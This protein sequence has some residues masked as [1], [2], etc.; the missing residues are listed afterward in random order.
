MKQN[1]RDEAEAVIQETQKLRE[2]IAELEDA[3]RTAETELETLML[4]LPNVPHESVPIGTSPEDNVIQFTWGTIPTFDFEPR[5]HWEL[6]DL[7]SLVDFERGAKVTGAGFPF[8][9][10]PGARLQRALVNFFLDLA[11]AEAGYVEMQAPFLVGEASARGTGQL[12]DKEDLMYEVSR[13]GL[14]LIPTAEVPVTN[15]LRDE[16]LDEGALPVKYCGYTACFRREAG[17][18]GKDVRGL[19]RLHQFDKV[20]LVQFVHPETSYAALET[21][22]EDAERA[23]QRLEIPY[24]RLLM[25]TGDMGFTQTKK[26][27]LEVWSAGQSRWLEVSSIS[28][29]EA[30][31]ARRAE[32]RFRAGQN[33]PTF[34]HTLNGSGLALPRVVA[35]LLE[36]NQAADGSVAIP[37]SLHSYTGFEKVG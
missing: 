35:A 7:H 12:P 31:Q 2:R 37:Q 13:D 27:D 18:Y 30:F 10:G 22:R 9:V 20:E 32:I 28:N 5:P 33:R 4:E 23:L 3:A 14:Y 6:A 16:I 26:Y 15:F 36:N 8:Y 1:R 29:F 21:M 24:R 19:N 25:C 17:S 34:V 11:V